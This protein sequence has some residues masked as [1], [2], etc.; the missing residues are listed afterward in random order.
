[1]RLLIFFTCFISHSLIAQNNFF[2]TYKTEGK[3]LL[4]K[5]LPLNEEAFRLMLSNETTISYSES[6]KKDNET[7]LNYK[8]IYKT[9]PLINKLDSITKIDSDFYVIGEYLLFKN[10]SEADSISSNLFYDALI[11]LFLDKKASKIVD[12]QITLP[13]SSSKT[14]FKIKIE[15]DGLA[16]YFITIDP[17]EY[18]PIK[19]ELKLTNQKN[20]V[21]GE[22]NI[23]ELNNYF[24]AYNI[25]RKED[26]NSFQKLNKLPL[27]DLQSTE[28]VDVNVKSHV[29]K[30]L[31]KGKKY[32]YYLGAIDYFGDEAIISEK[33]QIYIGKDVD[34]FIEIDTIKAV[35]STREIYVTITPL[36]DSVQPNTSNLLLYRSSDIKAPFED[37]TVLSK[38]SNTSKSAKFVVD[39][40]KTGDIFYYVVIAISEDNDSV[41]SNPYYFFTLDQEPP[42]IVSEFKGNIDSLGVV[43][44][45]WIAPQDKDIKG[46][47]LFRANSKKEEFVE[48]TKDL[49]NE[50]QFS[51]TLA[52]NTLTND[53]YYFVRVVDNNYNN[54]KN[55]DTLLLIKTDTIAPIV[56]AF[57]DY[58]STEEGITLKWFNSTS[59][60]LKSQYLLRS[61]EN[62]T[63]TIFRW[64]DQV[65]SFVD[66]S[67]S[68]GKSYE[69]Q[70]LSIDKSKNFSKSNV[71]TV[72]FELGYRDAIKQFTA[73]VNQANKSI[74]LNWDDPNQKETYSYQIFK[75]RGDGK[76]FLYKTLLVSPDFKN[77]FE[78]KDLKINTVYKYQIKAILLNGLSTVMSKEVIINY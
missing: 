12:H 41:K 74:V 73:E 49:K 29:D 31:K 60:D 70:L 2:H 65:S 28:L 63:D 22:W 30:N 52:L 7:I 27:L 46:Y 34:A 26:N 51:D 62:I 16:P 68:S 15:I 24:C 37:I 64:L 43:K 56:A 18:K 66:S 48:L 23:K 39:G 4:V 75:C 40:Y 45:S 53:I 35:N 25:Y 20:V 47:R 58:S 57:K 13:I 71:L 76:F 50:T 6:S 61:Y 77:T 3:S 11:Q 5:W 72:N 38:I 8:Q 9:K 55:S 10:A 42:E 54:S 17:K 32:T 69:Y 33:K 67:V 1:M 21:Y 36:A 19:P 78:D 44:L 59:E 14:I